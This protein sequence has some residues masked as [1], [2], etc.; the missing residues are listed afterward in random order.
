M[1][2]RNVPEADLQCERGTGR[3]PPPPR[4]RCRD[5]RRSR[6]QGGAGAVIRVGISGAN[7]TMGRL[8]IN[9]IRDADDLEIGRMQPLFFVKEGAHRSLHG[10][11]GTGSPS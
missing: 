6:R 7:G 8:T 9:A 10:Q 3:F 4:R 11:A 2:G 1:N 5:P